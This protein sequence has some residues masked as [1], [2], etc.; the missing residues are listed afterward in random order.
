[1]YTLQAG[2]APKHARAGSYAHVLQRYSDSA[3][4]G[5]FLW[6]IK[7]ATGRNPQSTVGDKPHQP[8]DFDFPK[9]EL[10]IKTVARRSFQSSWLKTWTWLHYD[11]QSDTCYCY[12]CMKAYK[13]KKLFQNTI[14]L[15]FI[16]KGFL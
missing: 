2:H 7:M 16:A 13:E 15:P 1:M 11:E 6:T 3:T 8:A 5:H 10:G 9:R 12:L 14:D 4:H